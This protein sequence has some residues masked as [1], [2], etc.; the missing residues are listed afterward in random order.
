M[1]PCLSRTLNDRD[2]AKCVENLAIKKHTASAASQLLLLMVD[3]EHSVLGPG[4]KNDFG[5]LPMLIAL[6]PSCK[7]FIPIGTRRCFHEKS[8]AKRF[9]WSSNAACTLDASMKRFASTAVGGDSDHSHIL[10]MVLEDAQ[11]SPKGISLPAIR[12]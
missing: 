12:E 6:P 11:R 9:I 8:V 2:S 3:D 1:Q 4:I 5:S 10:A 7:T